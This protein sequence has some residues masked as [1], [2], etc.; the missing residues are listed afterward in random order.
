MLTYKLKNINISFYFNVWRRYWENK[1]KEFTTINSCQH[2]SV[3]ELQIADVTVWMTHISS[4]KY[5][6]FVHIISL[7]NVLDKNK[8][9]MLCII[10]FQFSKILSL[11]NI[12]RKVLF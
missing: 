12:K 3:T 1:K 10:Y 7:K 9:K 2:D 6:K 11:I 5:K 4:L 8:K